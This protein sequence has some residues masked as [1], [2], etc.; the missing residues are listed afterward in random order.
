MLYVNNV[1][2]GVMDRVAN[3]PAGIDVGPIEGH[4]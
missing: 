3:D 1:M 4:N 2:A